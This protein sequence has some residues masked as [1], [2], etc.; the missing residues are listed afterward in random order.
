MSLRPILELAV[1]HHHSGPQTSRDV[2]PAV[3]PEDL[4]PLIAAAGDE[5]AGLAKRMV[6]EAC[7]W[8]LEDRVSRLKRKSRRC[9]DLE[10][11][12]KVELFWDAREVSWRAENILAAVGHLMTLARPSPA[13]E[14][15]WG[16]V[17]WEACVEAI[18]GNSASSSSSSSSSSPSV[19]GALMV[20]LRDV[21]TTLNRSIV[22]LGGKRG[23]VADDEGDA[24]TIYRHFLDNTLSRTSQIAI[25]QPAANPSTPLRYEPPDPRRLDPLVLSVAVRVMKREQQLAEQGT[26]A[27][28]A[29]DILGSGSDHGITANTHTPFAA[30][31]PLPPPQPMEGWIR[32]TI[33]RRGTDQQPPPPPQQQQQQQQQPPSTSPP[34]PQPSP[35]PPPSQPA[36]QPSPSPNSAEGTFSSNAVGIRG[37]RGEADSGGISPY[38]TGGPSVSEQATDLDAMLKDVV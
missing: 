10:R 15:F 32:S 11:M 37:P 22:K 30:T 23:E 4:A 6:L 9:A 1:E 2:D 3:T 8:L 26:V 12:A 17:L 18:R 34:T 21:E 20:S 29:N 35:P 27:D 25:V 31:V 24:E 5:M 33:R 16:G 28:E 13:P 38:G 19:A 36:Q 14:H 7:L